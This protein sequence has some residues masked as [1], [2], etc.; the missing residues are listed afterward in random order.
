TYETDHVA[1]IGAQAVRGHR[2][3]P[4]QVGELAEEV[5]IP[6]L[7]AIGQSMSGRA[8]EIVRGPV[9]AGGLP[10]AQVVDQCQKVEIVKMA[11]HLPDARC[12]AHGG[13]PLTEGVYLNNDSAV[14]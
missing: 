10:D 14:L 5:D 1:R 13:A 3:C 4:L 9:L 12:D 6:H 7:F 2:T 8:Q 11:K